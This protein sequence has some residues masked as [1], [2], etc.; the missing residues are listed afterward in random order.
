[1]VQKSIQIVLEAVYEPTFDDASHGFRPG[2]ACHSTLKLVTYKLKPTKWV[3]EGGISKC[4]DTIPHKGLIDI[5]KKKIICEKTTTLIKCSLQAGYID[6]G[7]LVP[8]QLED[9]RSVLNPILCNIFVNE[10]DL[11]VGKFKESFDCA[12]APHCPAGNLFKQKKYKLVARRL[13]KA[14]KAL[15]DTLQINK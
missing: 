10:L 5:L 15:L 7:Q 6:M 8:N 1:V 12:S 11:F 13:A 9:K 14:R 4:L 2:R 3:I